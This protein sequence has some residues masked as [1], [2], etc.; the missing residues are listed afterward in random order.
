MMLS[1]MGLWNLIEDILPSPAEIKASCP[2]FHRNPLVYRENVVFSFSLPFIR[3]TIAPEIPQH[4]EF[5]P[6]SSSIVPNPT[7]NKNQ[8][9]KGEEEKKVKR[10]QNGGHHRRH[11]T[12]S[13]QPHLRNNNPSNAHKSE[14][15]SE[16]AQYCRDS[17][18]HWTAEHDH[19][20]TAE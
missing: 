15:A 6:L 8:K 12:Q 3:T 4:P 11:L 17:L 7:K 2:E 1:T 14:A 20:G 19:I 5:V 18:L 16:A 10:I 13:G 9:T